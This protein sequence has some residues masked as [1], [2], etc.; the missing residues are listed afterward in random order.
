MNNISNTDHE[1]FT[2]EVFD[3]FEDLKTGF[4]N[5][6]STNIKCIHTN[7]RSCRLNWDS[8]L[9]EF[10]TAEIPWDIIIFTEINI[11][12]NETGVYNINNY[13]KF[14]NCRK[15]QRG[16]GIL[17]FF[18]EETIKNVSSK[19]IK[20][21]ENDAIAL[22]FQLNSQLFE[23]IA[24]YKKPSASR[25]KFIKELK[26][27]LK[28]KCQK[29][30]LILIGDFNFNVL[31][32]SQD[33]SEKNDIE[34]FENV[35][36]SLGFSQQINSPTREEIRN[37]KIIKSCIDLI[38]NKTKNWD[39][40]SYVIKIKLADHYFTAFQLFDSKAFEATKSFRQH[41]CFK[42][43]HTNIVRQLNNINWNFMNILKDP[44]QIYT[45]IENKVTAIYENNKTIY[46]INKPV[47]RTFKNE[48][49]TIDLLS[50]I[51]RK[52]KLW[53]QISKLANPTK[54][55]L[56][57][58][59]ELNKD[60]KNN[61]KFEKQTHYKS[62]FNSNHN[63]SAKIWEKINL[64]CGKNKEKLNIDEQIKK[65]FCN[66]NTDTICSNFADCYQQ[67][68]PK[69]KLAKKGSKPKNPHKRPYLNASKTE[70]TIQILKPTLY[71]IL[72]IINNMNI[73][74]SCGHDGFFMD[75]FFQT[76]NQTAYFMHILISAI[77]ETE[78][79][80]SNMK[81]QVLRPIYKKGD[82]Q[83]HNNYR[84][85]ALL[86]V[87]NKI[88]EKFFATRI[89]NFLRKN[90]I[91]NKH[92]FGFQQRKGTVDALKCINNNINRA[93]HEG[94]HVGAVFIDLKKAFDTLDKE[95][96]FGKLYKYGVRGK[97][98]NIMINYLTNRTSSVKI[99]DTY[100][101]WKE[102]EY[103]VPQGS[104]L[105]PILFLIYINDIADYNF[106]SLL[107]LYADDVCMISINFN[108]ET[109]IKNLQS[110][111]NKINDYFTENELYISAEKT[112]FMHITTSHMTKKHCSVSLHDINCSKNATCACK[113]LKQ[114][115]NTKYLGLEIDDNWKFYDHI[116][117]LITKIR[118]I[119]PSLY[120]IKDYINKT[121]KK[122]LYEAWILSKV[123][124]A[125]NIF[126]STSTNLI[127]RLQRT[128]NKAVKVLFGKSNGKT[129]KEIYAENQ[130]FTF[131]QLY[132][133]TIITNN[134][135]DFTYKTFNQRPSR[136]NN[137][138][139]QTPPWRNS[140]GK[141]VMA[142]VVPSLFNEIPSCLRNITSANTMR[143]H[144]KNWILGI[145]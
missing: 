95:I 107:T 69:L 108:Q 55:Q 130:L 113:K 94:K 18:K 96:L 7:I 12:D 71:D 44:N 80:P 90:N 106:T 136:T 87:L 109:M 8:W 110:D 22:N 92:Q 74:K 23:L 144:L 133:Y 11:G 58:Y 14:Y 89:M 119:I 60:V 61:I 142:Y 59:K 25:I 131:R 116:E 132:T 43:N 66:Q 13:Q 65:T 63:D 140:Y 24:L 88:V 102:V 67:E 141:R 124:Y 29:L 126:G 1:D 5:S 137:A 77:I 125:C 115:T 62:F 54:E 118:Q 47:S 128:I 145:M 38:Y 129:T 104:L 46:K 32:G 42:Y 86:P 31:K 41:Y 139:L 56:E 127:D 49:M 52:N 35:M 83:D 82:K 16:G 72:R 3:N 28:N 134:Y 100:S 103:G 120:M 20:I 30:N 114:V 138:W 97:F 122:T 81:K 123:R 117:N 91:L 73:K 98:L 78:I 6:A 33:V 10:E 34:K 99:G 15:N 121:V 68:V 85:I 53:S 40:K 135:F 2:N 111:F 48:W 26:D 4:I 70:N 79:W 105:G 57:R 19:N 112:C 39:C 50:K 93:L 101:K 37:N 21:E 84:P 27:H 75:H 17:I 45:E 51:N 9:A 76:K 36:A 64:I 143:K